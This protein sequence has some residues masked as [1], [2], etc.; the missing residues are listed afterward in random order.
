MLPVGL[1]WSGLVAVE[2]PLMSASKKERTG[3]QRQGPTYP[4]LSVRMLRLIL[5]LG[6]FHR[7]GDT[8]RARVRLVVAVEGAGWKRCG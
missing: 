5:R 1:A 4:A 8:P 2:E 6:A 7:C 3:D